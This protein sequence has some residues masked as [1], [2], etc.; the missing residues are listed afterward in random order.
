MQRKDIAVHESDDKGHLQN[1]LQAM[2]EMKQDLSTAKDVISF[3]EKKDKAITFRMTK[4]DT[5]TNTKKNFLSP[6]FFTGPKGYHMVIG[7][8][9][10]GVERGKGTHVSVFAILKRGKYDND[11][12]WPFVGNVNVTL[13]NQQEN[14]NHF[15][16]V[17]RV[18][19]AHNINIDGYLGITTFFPHDK[20]GYDPVKNTQYMKDDTLFFQASVDSPSYRL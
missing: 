1:A 8:I 10:Q 5:Y 12:S 7:I 2:V 16:D 4:F 20:L 19:E 6:H 17:I 15:E 3:M 18:E 14:K 13:L 9:P 11:L